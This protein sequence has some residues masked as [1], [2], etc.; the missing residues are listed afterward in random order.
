MG[1]W[2][3]M[4]VYRGAHRPLCRTYLNTLETLQPAFA[5]PAFPWEPCRRTPMSAR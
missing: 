5:A 3:L 2:R 1:G 4:V